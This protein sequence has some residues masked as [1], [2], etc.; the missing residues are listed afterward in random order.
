MLQ[1][2]SANGGDGLQVQPLPPSHSPAPPV[3][4]PALSS[5]C[6]AVHIVAVVAARLD[7]S[8]VRQLMIILQPLFCA[9]S[10]TGSYGVNKSKG[11]MRN[12]AKPG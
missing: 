4:Y 7:E 11:T 3:F 2:A 6:V 5:S 8:A 10:R 9:E 1:A 12:S